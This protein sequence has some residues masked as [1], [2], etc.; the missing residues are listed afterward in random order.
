MHLSR[1]GR[2]GGAHLRQGTRRVLRLQPAA[3]CSA[4]SIR[5]KPSTSTAPASNSS[6]AAISGKARRAMRRPTIRD[7]QK[8]YRAAVGIDDN[9]AAVGDP[10]DVSTAS[11]MFGCWET[12]YVIKK[13]MED[14]RLQG[15][16]RPRQAGRG[17]RGADRVRRGAR[18]SA[19]RQDLQ[20]Q[21]PPGASAS[22]TS[23]RSKAASSRW[24]TRPRSRTGFTSRKATTRRRRCST[25]VRSR[26]RFASARPLRLGC[27]GHARPP[28][29]RGRTR[30][31]P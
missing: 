28:A 8:A 6:T 15:A 4:S 21:D 25:L 9:G 7:A 27:D 19:G 31:A 2:P 12:L 16:G 30:D 20:R 10:K 14:S 18:A 23:P 1:H 5:W 24:S 13:A 26:R 3:S 11:H 29:M 17:D 22:R